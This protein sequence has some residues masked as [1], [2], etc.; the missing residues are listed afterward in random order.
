MQFGRRK[1]LGLDAH[2]IDML[3]RPDNPEAK[4]FV[5]P[6]GGIGSENGE[7]HRIV[8]E[9]CLTQDRL[10]DLSPNAIALM[11]WQELRLQQFPLRRLTNDLD[12]SDRSALELQ[13]LR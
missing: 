6:L 8:G 2:F 1:G 12:H 9:L 10:N 3:S 13:H 4:T 7:D 11:L 5:E